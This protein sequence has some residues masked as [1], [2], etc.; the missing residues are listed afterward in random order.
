MRWCTSARTACPDALHATSIG[1]TTQSHR[2]VSRLP[3]RA[4]RAMRNPDSNQALF[5]AARSGNAAQCRG[6]VADGAG[7]SVRWSYARGRTAH[8]R[9]AIRAR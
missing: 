6:L 9:T 8:A 3:S 2:S 7:V 4:E 1:P 5:G